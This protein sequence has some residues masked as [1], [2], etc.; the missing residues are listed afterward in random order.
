[1][2][3]TAE[4]YAASLP[5]SPAEEYLAA[6]GIDPAAASTAHLGWT[7]KPV[8]GHESYSGMLAI[9]YWTRGGVVGMK[10]RVVDDRPGPRYLALTGQTITMYNVEAVI[11]HQ[12]YVVIC[13]GELDTV[14]THHVCGLNA[15]GIPGVNSWKPHHQRVLKGFND[16]FILADNDDKDNGDNPGQDLAAKILR[17]IPWARNIMLPRGMD[18]SE[19]VLTNGKDALAPLLGI[20]ASSD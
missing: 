12:P 16:V 7:G 1:M 5:G 14:V 8:P 2:T 11:S 9:P 19:Y 20:G 6:R 3:E 4:Q 10:F 18:V 15:V 13:E 17:H